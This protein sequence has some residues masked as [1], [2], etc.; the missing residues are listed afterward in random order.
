[1][2]SA[3]NEKAA[4]LTAANTNFESTVIVTSYCGDG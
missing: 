1:V 4:A 3:S 2:G